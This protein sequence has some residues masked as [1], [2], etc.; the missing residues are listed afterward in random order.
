MTGHLVLSTLHTNDAV[1]SADRLLDMGAE[2]YLIAAALRAVISQRLVRRICTSCKSEY[3][4]D[5]QESSWLTSIEQ[6]LSRIQFQYGQGCPQCNN[7]G[8][9]GRL[10]VYEYMEP[11]EPMLAAL[12]NSDAA[13]FADA[14]RTNPAFHSLR[15]SA[16]DYA[17]QGLTSL[18]EVMRISGETEEADIKEWGKLAAEALQ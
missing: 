15:D 13:G 3:T 16:M 9:S 5:L 12:R 6:D 18:E 1:S 2:G 4:P 10:G 8:Y 11:S 7:T 17:M 14:A